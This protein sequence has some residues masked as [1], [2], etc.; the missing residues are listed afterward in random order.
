[1]S[2]LPTIARTAAEQIVPQAFTGHYIRDAHEEIL[3]Q[4]ERAAEI[5]VAA[6]H[7]ATNHATAERDAAVAELAARHERTHRMAD[8]DCPHCEGQG[9]ITCKWDVRCGQQCTACAS[10]NIP[11]P[12][13]HRGRGGAWQP[14]VGPC[15]C[16]VC[17]VERLANRKDSH[18]PIP[19]GQ[20]PRQS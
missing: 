1:M 7:A 15:V 20:T 2:E 4:T 18:G 13:G 16:E 6:I 9:V 8:P 5:I 19:T 12:Y 10:A 11:D 3:R 14:G 17:K